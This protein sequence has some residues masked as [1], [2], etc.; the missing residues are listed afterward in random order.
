MV[1]TE[2]SG[3]EA[4]SGAGGLRG[5]LTSLVQ[6]GFKQ[7]RSQFVALFVRGLSVLAGFSVTYMIGRNFGA[8]VTGQYAL[9][10]QTAM[11]LGVVGLFGLDV[12]VVRHLSRAVAEEKKLA[13]AVF[14]RIMA[15]SWGML[16]LVIV[17][18]WLGG[19]PAWRL[20]FGDVVDRSLLL[21][22]V[23][24]LIGRGSAQLIGGLLRSQ[25]RFALG[26][27]V[28]ALFTPLATAFALAT[29]IATSLEDA[30]WATTIGALSATAIGIIAVFSHVSNASEALFVPVKSLI[31]S[32]LPL[33]GAGLALVLGEWYGLAVAAQ[34]L[35]A[36]E[37]GFYRVSFQ[38]S[39]ALMMLSVTLFSVYSAQI[40]T[41]FHAGRRDEAAKLAQSAVRLSVALA[42][43]T[44]ILLIVGGRF[45]LGLIGPQ[46][47]EALPVLWTLV[48]GQMLIALTGPSGLVLAMSG[49]EKL[50]LIISLTGTGALLVL[51]PI[52]A[53]HTGLVGLA[54]CISTILVCRNLAAYAFVKLRLG[55]N[56]WA[57]TAR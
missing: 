14:A 10:T 43:P 22:L 39:G 2:K 57:G 28:V 4:Q 54:I 36:A 13:F 16:A 6:A 15:I 42:V 53:Y 25:H 19:E 26:I 48:I 17:I 30:L 33:W 11:F 23:L 18:M 21:I 34:V 1:Q 47:L 56:I 27:A 44:A 52:A 3:D 8:A 55:I 7:Y 32:S 35:G 40:S 46:F 49:N 12:S 41:A 50:N 20:F 29:G 51:A 5:K 24:M 31:S 9:I 37:A 45:L 38:L